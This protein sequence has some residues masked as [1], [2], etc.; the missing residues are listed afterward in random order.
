M[1]LS[2]A[3][4]P[5]L[6]DVSPEARQIGVWIRSVVVMQRMTNPSQ[7]LCLSDSDVNGRETVPQMALRHLVGGG[8]RSCMRLLTRDSRK[9]GTITE[10]SLPL[11]S[12]RYRCAL[13]CA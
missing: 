7:N 10:L 8:V 11:R 2:R 5:S 6:Y 4:S 9:H 12:R 1:M 13:R 3:I